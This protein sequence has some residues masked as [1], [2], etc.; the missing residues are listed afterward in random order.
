[1]SNGIYVLWNPPLS[2]SS[3]TESGVNGSRAPSSRG[4]VAGSELGLDQHADGVERARDVVVAL[5]SV[6]RVEEQREP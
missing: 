1:M 6:S 3:F 4:L 5:G 2:V